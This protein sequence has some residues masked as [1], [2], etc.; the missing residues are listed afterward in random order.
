MTADHTVEE[1]AVL[2]RAAALADERRAANDA[3]VAGMAAES[4][5]DVMRG[6]LGAQVARRARD[7]GQLDLGGV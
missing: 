6:R 2:D 7:R 3:R 1:Q 4:V 5:T